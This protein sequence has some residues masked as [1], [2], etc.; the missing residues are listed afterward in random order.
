MKKFVAVLMT[1]TVL[2]GFASCS[3]NNRNRDDADPDANI[4]ELK[5]IDGPM[6]EITST[7]RLPVPEGTDIDN[8]VIVNYDGSVTGETYTV[9]EISDDD[10][11]TLYNFCVKSIKNDT[12]ADYYEE[13]C[14]GQT[15]C[16]TFYDEEGEAHLIYDGYTYDNRELNAIMHIVYSYNPE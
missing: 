2:F 3:K 1:I 14:D 5:T 15:Y 13:V 4:E 12:F 16:F 8:T 7:V 11:M 9:P 10:Y 6:L